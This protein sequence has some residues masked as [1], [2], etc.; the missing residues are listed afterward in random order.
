LSVQ[1]LYETGAWKADSGE[2]PFQNA[3]LGSGAAAVNSLKNYEICKNFH[4]M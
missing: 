1:M 3:D 4:F 2:K